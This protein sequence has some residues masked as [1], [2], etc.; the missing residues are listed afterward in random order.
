MADEPT[1]VTRLRLLT[2]QRGRLL[3]ALDDQI[4][5][6]YFDARVE[7]CFEEALEVGPWSRTVAVRAT[8]N[9]NEALGRHVRWYG[10]ATASQDGT[11]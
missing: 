8:R 9:V 3:G 1:P 5:Q 2:E 4:A 11:D 6:A 7:G 10:F